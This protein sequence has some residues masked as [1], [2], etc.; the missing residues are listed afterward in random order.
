M[1]DSSFTTRAN[2]VDAMGCTTTPT[3]A[4]W[5]TCQFSLT[6]F[7]ARFWSLVE[8]KASAQKVKSTASGGIAKLEERWE[9]LDEARDISLAGAWAEQEEQRGY[10]RQRAPEGIHESSSEPSWWSGGRATLMM[11][12]FLSPSL[13]WSFLFYFFYIY[14]SLIHQ[15]Y[16]TG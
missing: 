12:A 11:R 1:L 15:S 4:R 14:P 2:L 13:F 9:W 3:C 10:S 5:A 8:D 6:L 16:C 7:K